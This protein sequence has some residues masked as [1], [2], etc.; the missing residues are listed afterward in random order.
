MTGFSRA[1]A[2]AREIAVAVEIKSVNGK[3]LDLRLRVP[4]GLDFL[5]TALRP[6]VQQRFSRGSLQIS[7]VVDLSGARVTPRIN[8]ELL[9]QLLVLTSDLV[10]RHN[11]S[12]PTADGLL[13]IRGVVDVPD[14][15]PDDAQRDAIAA[16]ARDA[17]QLALADLEKARIAEGEALRAVLRAQV[18]AIG[19]LALRA[20]ADPARSPQAIRD[21][22]AQQVA[23][24]MEA[25]SSLDPARL[26]AEAAVLAAKA[27]IRE[28][29]DRLFAHVSSAR[30]LLEGGGAIGRRLDFLAQE[31][32]RESNTLCSK[33]NAVSITA[34]GLELKVLTDQFREQVQNLE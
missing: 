34:I 6:L 19:D 16:V 26:H 17:M 32:N 5:D 31:I 4:P 13:A 18:A 23:M 29:I 8:Q 10:T 20:E 24:L 15:D 2:N 22:L 9:D 33:S 28:E 25:A 12:P 14:N 3:G 27:D 11:A 7:V 21:R 1:S 30:A